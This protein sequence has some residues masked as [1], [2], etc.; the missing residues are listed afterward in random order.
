MLDFVD[1][2]QENKGYTFPVEEGDF[3]N[4]WAEFAA[5]HVF[6]IVGE[7]KVGFINSKLVYLNVGVMYKGFR[8]MNSTEA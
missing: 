6:S 8:N 3:H 4:R 1:W 2:I 7:H 5:K